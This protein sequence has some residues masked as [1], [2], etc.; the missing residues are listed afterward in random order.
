MDIL[1]GHMK[2]I[3]LGE[4]DNNVNYDFRETCFGIVKKGNEFYLTSKK[5]EISL[6]G[7]GVEPGESHLE[8]L[9]REFIEEAGLTIT[10]CNEFVTI[11]CYWLTK[12]Q[13]NMESLANFYIVE[14]SDTVVLATEEGSKLVKVSEKELRD[15][16]ALPYQKKAIELY[17]ELDK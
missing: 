8:T 6:I 3:V 1:G 13:K 10:E 7:G 5:G 14:V 9:K 12:N 16:L 2:K 15:S 11:D 17:L 4:K